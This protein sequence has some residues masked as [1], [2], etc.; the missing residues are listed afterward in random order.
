M[1][2]ISIN[3]I[4]V[5]KLNQCVKKCCSVSDSLYLE[6]SGDSL[7]GLIADNVKLHRFKQM[8]EG[9]C[10]DVY[11]TL[12][13]AAVYLCRTCCDAHAK[14]D[15]RKEGLFKIEF[16]GHEM[17]SLCSKTYVARNAKTNELKVSTK[18]VNKRNLEHPLDDCRRALMEK[19]TV[20]VQNRGIRLKDSILR[21]YFQNKIGFNFFYCKRVVQSDLISTKPLDIVLSPYPL[22]TCGL[23]NKVSA[24]VQ[25]PSAE[26]I[27]CLDCC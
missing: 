17:I 7:E 21:T 1:S 19:C 16:E 18:G 9:R 2:G 26:R 27:L 4:I 23:C 3:K 8:T 12:E 10:D 11:N 25:N 6:I 5:R 24:D 15:R 13:D 22:Y 14:Y 20:E